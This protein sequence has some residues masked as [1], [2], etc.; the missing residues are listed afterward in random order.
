M[1]HPRGGRIR[2]DI[3]STTATVNTNQIA[4]LASENQA[5]GEMLPH[6][7]AFHAL[8]ILVALG[9]ADALLTPQANDTALKVTGEIVSQSYCEQSDHNSFVLVG[10]VRIRAANISNENLI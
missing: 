8:I 4:A 10:K 9:M 7:I 2:L 1:G 3:S 6:R 5:R